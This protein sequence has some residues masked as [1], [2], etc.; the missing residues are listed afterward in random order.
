MALAKVAPKSPSSFVKAEEEAKLRLI[1]SS[2]GEYGTGKTTF[3]LGAPGPIYILSF[4][5]GLEGVVE[6]FQKE[7][8]IYVAEY[9]WTPTDD[10]EQEHAIDLRDKV[11]ADFEYAC[12]NGRTVVLD[13]ET[14]MWELF[15]Y[16]E[17]GAPND[18]PLDYPK[19]N[20]RYRKFINTPKA[21][22]INFGVIQGMKEK[23]VKRVNPK[24]GALGA[25]GSGD[26]IPAGFSE[27]EGLVHVNLY[28]YRENG[29]MFFR[30]GKARGPGSRDVQDNT[31][32][33]VTFK[34]FAQLVF[35]ESE[36]SDWE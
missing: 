36:E 28:H 20:Q 23:W 26:R 6:P 8:D 1:A 4:D 13:K 24:T 5:K 27:I 2:S 33:N 22:D 19:L 29:V 35:P 30:T 21:L 18:S 7:K 12:H 14:D 3:W 25:V 31:Y 11:I 17:F 32:E 9:D 34:E 15:R 16:A 10:L